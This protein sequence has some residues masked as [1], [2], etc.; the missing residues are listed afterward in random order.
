M[1]KNNFFDQ[2]TNLT[3]SK[4]LIY[5]QYISKYL[6][7]VLMQYGRCFIADFFCGRGKNAQEAGSPLVL[8]DVARKT[9][10]SPILKAKYPNAEIMVIFSDDNKECCNDLQKYLHNIS[11]PN[12]ITVLGPYCEKF[13]TIKSKTIK[14]FDKI[15]PPKFFFLDPFTYSDIKLADIKDLMSIQAAEVLL[16]LPTFHSYRFVKRANKI[17]ALKH[18]LE[19]FTD[20]GCV[21]YKDINDFNRSIKQRLIKE[22]GLEYVR[23][24]GLDDGTRKNALFYLTRHPKGM[25]LMNNL[26]WKHSQDGTNIR[27]KKDTNLRLF[28][29]SKL[30]NNYMLM[31]D[32]LQSYIQRKK[33]ISNVDIINFIAKQGFVTKYANEILKQMQKQNKIN[34]THLN[35]KKTQ[36]FYVSMANWNNK[37]AIINYKG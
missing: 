37:L 22:I 34:V 11:L 20:R 30:T 19:D 36:S 3:A 17:M 24:V 31:K 14:V 1:T 35:R 10:K 16:F 25:L 27:T 7:A 6:P 33:R 29:T 21:D 9:L 26:V 28:D 12:Q 4:I 5:R 32:L 2:Q 18:F 23:D 8:L 15:R 13:D